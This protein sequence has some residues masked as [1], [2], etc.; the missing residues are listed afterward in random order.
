M[1]GEKSSS[2]PSNEMLHKGC[3]SLISIA[4]WRIYYINLMM[5][6]QLLLLLFINIYRVFYICYIHG[7]TWKVME[8]DIDTYWKN[9][10]LFL[11]G[12]SI[13]QHYYSYY[14]GS[15][16]HVVF[17]DE[18]IQ[19]SELSPGLKDILL[20]LKS[21]NMGII[22]YIMESS[23]HSSS[24]KSYYYWSPNTWAFFV[25]L[26][27]HLSFHLVWKSYYYWSPKMIDFGR[28]FPSIY[29]NYQTFT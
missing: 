25:I 5:I 21:Q 29:L 8:Y 27:N 16:L 12:N 13:L 10:I 19:S 26:W 3:K 23:E 15:Y 17:N 9:I 4:K 24:L 2:S 18:C 28:Y 6:I 22:Y 1:H 7:S 11:H 20:L 14:I